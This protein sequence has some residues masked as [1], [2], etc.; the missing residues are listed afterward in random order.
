MQRRHFLAGILATSTAAL[1][2]G[3]MPA[4]TGGTRNPR[5]A[6]NYG[7]DGQMRDLSAVERTQAGEARRIFDHFNATGSLP[8]L[9]GDPADA[10]LARWTQAVAAVEAQQSAGIDDLLALA[11]PFADGLLV[12]ETASAAGR[13]TQRPA[14]PGVSGGRVT[15][16]SGTVVEMTLF[17]HC[18]DP[19]LPAPGAGEKLLLTSASAY[20]ADVLRPTYRCALDME[21]QGSLSRDKTQEVIWAV[22]TASER[23]TPYLGRIG[24]TAAA[25]MEQQCPGSIQ[26]L[27]K[28]RQDILYGA[29]AQMNRLLGSL[30]SVSLNGRKINLLEGGGGET[31]AQILDDITR[32][33][34][35]GTIPD[36]DSDHS[37]LAAGVAAVARGVGPLRVRIRIANTSDTT[38]VFDPVDWIAETRRAAQRIALPP[39][40]DISFSQP[41]F[42]GPAGDAA[43]TARRLHDRFAAD[44]SKFT[45]SGE[46]GKIAI[47]QVAAESSGELEAI[48]KTVK[49]RMGKALVPPAGIGATLLHGYQSITRHSW[50]MS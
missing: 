36:D 18:L 46:P 22:R 2:S 47:P 1:L 4:T 37:M 24:G 13:K 31:V 25:H 23:E 34:I 6:V 7:V 42:A 43:A 5:A 33:T 32:R 49:T 20:I 10:I 27:V 9:T 12:I 11:Q 29:D 3:C 26:N 39:V 19:K 41:G 50:R 14:K 17:G 44:L 38:F 28:Y 35:P 15:I 30:F 40:A 48:A 45:V 21:F 8:R 16:P